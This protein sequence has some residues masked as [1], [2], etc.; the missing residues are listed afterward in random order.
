M[1][2]LITNKYRDMDFQSLNKEELSSLVRSLE[3]DISWTENDLKNSAIGEDVDALLDVLNLYKKYR[4]Q[5]LK[6]LK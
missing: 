5:V 3:C 6:L 2:A 1:K 4:K